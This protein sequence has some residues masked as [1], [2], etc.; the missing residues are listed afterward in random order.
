MISIAILGVAGRMGQR[1]VALAKEA[2]D[3]NIVAALE[4]PDHPLIE[5]DAGEVAGVDCLKPS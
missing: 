1:L 2:G 3:F 5:T 4:R